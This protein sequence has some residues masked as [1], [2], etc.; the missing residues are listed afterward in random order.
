MIMMILE[1]PGFRGDPVMRCGLRSPWI[2]LKIERSPDRRRS[3]PPIE[4]TGSP[5]AFVFSGGTGDDEHRRLLS[6]EFNREGV[7]IRTTSKPARG[8]L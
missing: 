4:A 3:E 8:V 5:G 1:R 7:L 2:P 6:G